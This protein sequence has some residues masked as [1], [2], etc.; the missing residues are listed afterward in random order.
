MTYTPAQSSHRTRHKSGARPRIGWR[1]WVTLPELGGARV[2]AKVDTGARTSAIHARN[3]RVE[4]RGRHAYVSFDIHPLQRDNSQVIRCKSLLVDQRSIRNSGG[5]AQD[6]L[7]IQTTAQI[8]PVSFPIELSLTQ[9]DEMGFR[10]LL[11]RAAVRN[12]FLID[13]GRS[14]LMGR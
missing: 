2:K 13:P 12:R 11:G 14:F 10:M 7:I 1:E 9:R 8:G 6:R 3:I 4:H 5:Q